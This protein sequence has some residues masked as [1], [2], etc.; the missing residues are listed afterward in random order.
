LTFIPDE[1]LEKEGAAKDASSS[2]LTQS[3]SQQQTPL[4]KSKRVT[5]TLP[6]PAAA[7]L[8]PE[9]QKWNDDIT[10]LFTMNSLHQV[11]RAVYETDNTILGLSNF[12]YGSL[13]MSFMRTLDVECFERIYLHQF[14][15]CDLVS[16]A[17]DLSMNDVIALLSVYK[18]VQN[19]KHQ[20]WKPSQLYKTVIKIMHSR[21]LHREEFKSSIKTLERKGLIV[22]VS[23]P[24]RNAGTADGCNEVYYKCE[25]TGMEFAHFWKHYP[26]LPSSFKEIM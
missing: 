25:L 13:I 21:G 5:L 24:Q 6:P 3:N 11:L 19:N 9:R 1:A 4:R 8:S 10:D 18:Q 7:A 23:V 20:P 22:P 14:C 15:R 2:S 16:I 12:L 17:M 26:N